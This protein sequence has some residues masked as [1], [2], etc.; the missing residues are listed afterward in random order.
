MATEDTLRLF[1]ALPCPPEQAAAICSWRDRQALG[2]RP[3]ALE[4]LHLTLAFL[5]AQPAARLDALR[6]LAAG[7]TS[8]SF[9]LTLNRLITLGKGF[10]CL[11]PSEAPP[12]LLQLGGSL[13]ERLGAL[14]IVLD[15]RPYLPHMTLA[16]QAPTQAQGAAATFGWKAERFVLYQSQNTTNGVRYSELG[17]WPLRSAAASD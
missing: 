13:A 15:S 8:D 5:G 2:G 11:A 9:E 17:S 14:G 12:A 3:V 10:V 1:F 6:H 16:R 7:V 4:N